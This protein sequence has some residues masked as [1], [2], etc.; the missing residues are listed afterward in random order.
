MQANAAE[1]LAAI[2]QSQGS[3]LA[4]GLT[5]P[6]FLEL[7]VSR[8]LTPAPGTTTHAL[9]VCIALLE[10]PLPPL[11]ADGGGLGGGAGAQP[12]PVAVVTQE[13]VRAEAI[14]CMS[15]SIAALV[16]LVEGPPPMAELPT[17]YGLL[18]PPV[19]ASRL[20]AVELLAA[21]LRTGSPIA[22]GCCW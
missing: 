1:I 7:L 18:R 19:G 12:D 11:G 9:N 6:E 2:A 22:G 20:K 16:A 13:A 17:T 21:L 3:P 8:A 15:K 4:R 10:P 14:R 5:S